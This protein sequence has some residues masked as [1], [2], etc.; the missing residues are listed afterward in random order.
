MK[1][2]E[3][4]TVTKLEAGERQLHVA[5]RIF[6]ERKDLLAVHTLAAA[7]LEILTQLGKARGFQSGVEHTIE[8]FPPELQRALRKAFR[9]QQSFLKHAGKDPNSKIPLWPNLTTFYLFDAAELA[10]KLTGRVSPEV[11]AFIGWFTVQR[12]D[13][14][15]SNRDP[16][17]T[18]LLRY[19]EYN[20][21]SNS[22]EDIIKV[23]DYLQ[24]NPDSLPVLKKD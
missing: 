5:I 9:H 14:F 10:Y 4:E 8:R 22:F 18:A 16:H 19:A 13:I 17:L 12:P 15:Q 24:A 1:D 20:G 6:F 3:F 7:A 23:M 2:P 21:F 11:G